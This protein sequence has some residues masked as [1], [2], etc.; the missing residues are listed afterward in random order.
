MSIGGRLR[1]SF[2]L[3]ALALFLL[4]GTPFYGQNQQIA[5][6]LSGTVTDPTG[7]T[8]TGAKV[9]LKSSQN[10]IIRTYSTQASGLYS[11]TLLPPAVYSLEVDVTGFKTY[12]QQGITLEA[13]QVA[14][15]NVRLTIGSATE[16]VEVSAQ[17]PLL[18]VDNANI[19]SDIS[20]RQVAELPLNLRNVISLAELNSSVSNTAEEQVVGAPGISGSADQDISF[21]NFGGT[22]F[23]TA[24][25]LL[26]GSWD[27]RVDWGG[28]IYVPS[29]DDVQE[30]KIQTNAFTSQYGWSSGNVI[31]VV[32]KSGTNRVHGDAWGFYRNSA[33]DARYFFNNANQPAF[34]RD[35][36][37]ATIGGPIIKNKLYFFAYYEGLKQET[38]ATFLATMPTTAERTGDFSAQLGPQQGTDYLGRPIYTGEIYNPFSTRQV[39]C[40]GV[41]A[42]TGDAVHCPAGATTEFI[43]DPVSGNI[44][45]GLGVSNI[46]P[47]GLMDSI[48][49]TT[50]QPVLIGPRPRP[51]L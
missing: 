2:L 46:V 7:L 30:F 4:V 18:N 10:G 27:T 17:A 42:V 26:D 50:L 1:T 19:T 49:S 11:F 51:M 12:R 31:N 32:T 23:D 47:A 21:L 9:T 41:D 37:G 39:T 25:Y 16:S 33:Y 14:E 20:A 6:T 3:G 35:Q 28:V 40:G 29:V 48:A 15:Q 22:F 13:G 45:T 43:R 8:M 24:E 34:H 5:A 38:P 44:T 36:Y